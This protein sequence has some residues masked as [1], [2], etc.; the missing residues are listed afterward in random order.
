MCHVVTFQ[1]EAA[2]WS[3]VH[4][5]VL[6][7]YRWDLVLTSHFTLEESDLLKSIKQKP[8]TGCS[9]RSKMF[10]MKS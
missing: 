7:C 2:Q 8:K 5:R 3:K 4:L 6:R 9:H 10:P 1:S